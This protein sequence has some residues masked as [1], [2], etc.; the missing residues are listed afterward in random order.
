MLNKIL[1]TVKNGTKGLS[2]KFNAIPKVIDLVVILFLSQ[3]SCQFHAQDK[4]VP[5]NCI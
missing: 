2:Y 3:F 1:E 5:H 4:T